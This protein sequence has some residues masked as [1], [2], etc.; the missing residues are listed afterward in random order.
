[1]LGIPSNYLCND[2]LEKKVD[3]RA[4]YKQQRGSNFDLQAITL[5][6]RFLFLAV[7]FHSANGSF[8]RH[9]KVECCSLSND[10]G[11]FCYWVANFYYIVIQEERY[12]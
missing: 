7:K 4:L 5:Y 11:L 6:V 1:M 3:R 9:R 8:Q 2:S 10:F 12:A